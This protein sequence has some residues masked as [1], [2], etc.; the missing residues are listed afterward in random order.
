MLLLDS[1]SYSALD[2]F[3]IYLF[4]SAL[5]TSAVRE[6]C[7]GNNALAAGERI[8]SVSLTPKR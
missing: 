6:R 4:T 3:L 5:F 7:G 2:N 1:R 8:A